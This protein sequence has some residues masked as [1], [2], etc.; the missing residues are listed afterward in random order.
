MVLQAGDRYVKQF[1]S[2]SIDYNLPLRFSIDIQSSDRHI[3]LWKDAI[4][5]YMSRQDEDID[6][7]TTDTE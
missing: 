3:Q 6:T 2:Y 7:P 1:Q 4:T 5:F